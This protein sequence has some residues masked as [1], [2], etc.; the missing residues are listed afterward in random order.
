MTEPE[1]VWANLSRPRVGLSARLHPD[2]TDVWLA[3]DPEARR[4]LLVRSSG[5]APGLTLASTRG[6][7]ATTELLEL[8]NQPRDVWTDIACLDPALNE[9]FVAVADNLAQEA[10]LHP[11]DPLE[12]VRRTLRTWQWFWGVDANA[13]SGYSALGLFGE[14]WFLDRWAPFPE[15]IDTWLGPTQARHD[16][17]SPAA[18]VEVKATTTRSDGSAVHQIAN[19][20]QLAQPETGTL[21]LFSLQVIRDANATNSLPHL[22]SRMRTR[23]SDRPDLLGTFDQKL[24]QAGWS[25]Q[26]A[27]RLLQTYRVVAEELYFV[28]EDFPKLTRK[29]FPEGIPAGVDDVSYTLNLSACLAWRVATLPAEV[30]DLLSAL[31]L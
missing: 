13:L 11:D 12:A 31:R 25:P 4:H 3:V 26:S 19:L 17:V 30:A 18:S 5:A 16:F 6:L 7:Q 8:E 10:R 22:I 1:D 14:L 27:E 9:T 28:D 23:L 2:S 15:A 20:D 29:S 24:A 21:H